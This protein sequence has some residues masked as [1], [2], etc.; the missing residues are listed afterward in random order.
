MKGKIPVWSSKNS[1]KNLRTANRKHQID[2]P[3]GP[4]LVFSSMPNKT[5]KSDFTPYKTKKPEMK[6]FNVCSWYFHR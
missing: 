3:Y 5:K 6:Q 4:S 2:R 1:G